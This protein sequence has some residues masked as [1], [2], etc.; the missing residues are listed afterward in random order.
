MSE[1]M[2]ETEGFRDDV[3]ESE[4]RRAPMPELPTYK[5]WNPNPKNPGQPVTPGVVMVSVT[6]RGAEKVKS[7]E[8]TDKVRAIIL[9]RSAGR[10]LAGG[11]GKNFNVQC[12]SH[13]YITDDTGK[14]MRP[15]L[16]IQQPLCR[17]AT[18]QDV[19]QIFSQWKGFDQAKIDAKVAEVTEG[20]GCLQV[21]GLKAADGS[22]IALCPSARWTKVGR[23]NIA[24][25]CQPREFIHA[26]DLD[27][28]REF[29]MELGGQSIKND[30][31]YV[32]PLFQFYAWIRAQGK[33]AVSFQY[34]VEISPLQN[35]AFYVVN[36]ANPQ[37][38]DEALLAEIEPRAH[39]AK[40]RYLRQASWL[41]KEEYE[42]RKA[43]AG[44][45]DDKSPQSIT[46]RPVQQPELPP[47]LQKPVSFDDD[48]IPFG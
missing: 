17:D 30:Q 19:A 38:I 46:S 16:K 9:F 22:L 15:S 20:T 32:S 23:R 12:Q 2:L 7:E 10:M 47:A 43:Q 21:C 11:E 6:G 39:D 35:G 34:E 41:P 5:V 3:E 18:A 27:R 40:D 26:Y 33:E 36:V 31:K 45:G 42:R 29:K 1:V 48:D 44:G 8:R 13:G 24:P 4:R 25:A 14:K 37:K 28:K